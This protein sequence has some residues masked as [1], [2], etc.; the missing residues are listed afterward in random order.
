MFCEQ[1]HDIYYQQDFCVT[2]IGN[3]ELIFQGLTTQKAQE[4]FAR[5]G[6]NA[7]TPPKTTPEW[8]KFCKQMFGGFSLLLW[9]GAIL[10]YFAYFIVATTYEEVPG[11]NVSRCIASTDAVFYISIRKQLCNCELCYLFAFSVRGVTS[12]VIKYGFL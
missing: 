2:Q 1:M 4:V 12:S 10:C 9:I 11:D 7:L 6:P 5:D 3:I 8:V